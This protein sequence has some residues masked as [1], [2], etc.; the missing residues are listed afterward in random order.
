[1]DE[2]RTLSAGTPIL[3]AGGC[4]VRFACADD[5]THVGLG[6]K[7][8]RFLDLDI[9]LAGQAVQE[10]ATERFLMLCSAETL[11][12]G[13]F[14]AKFVAAIA[15]CQTSSKNTESMNAGP[16]FQMRKRAGDL[17]LDLWTMY[18]ALGRISSR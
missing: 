5:L 4:C 1:M 16:S 2:R 14:F 13:S 8:A 17:Q 6:R 18:V 9:V 7:L 12:P 11:P 3:Q 15:V 10:E